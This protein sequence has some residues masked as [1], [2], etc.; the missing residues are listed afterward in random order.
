M[1][2]INNS[3]WL[4]FIQFCPWL[5]TKQGLR[6]TDTQHLGVAGKKKSAEVADVLISSK[7]KY[8]ARQCRAAYHEFATFDTAAQALP[9]TF[10]P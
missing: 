5:R 10:K 2:R 4:V 1:K 7:S 3:G 8:V 9:D 6:G